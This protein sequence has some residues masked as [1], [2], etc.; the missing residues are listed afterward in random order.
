MKNRILKIKLSQKRKTFELELRKYTFLTSS[1]NNFWWYDI[2]Q[3]I[4]LLNLEEHRLS[5]ALEGSTEPS[6]HIKELTDIELLHKVYYQGFSFDLSLVNSDLSL[7]NKE[8]SVTPK[9]PLEGITFRQRENYEDV[10]NSLKWP[11]SDM[12]L[13]YPLRVA[14]GAFAS[15]YI[16]TMSMFNII[17]NDIPEGIRTRLREEYPFIDNED[18]SYYHIDKEGNVVNC[19]GVVDGVRQMIDT[20]EWYEHQ[21][22]MN[23]YYEILNYVK[24]LSN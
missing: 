15:Q 9:Q 14:D 12:H 19:M 10:V 6:G 21:A 11:V 17:Y 4:E 13:F 3:V 2:K 23:L 1:P 16:Y 20:P 22:Q 5:W 8:L 18:I 7:V 24:P